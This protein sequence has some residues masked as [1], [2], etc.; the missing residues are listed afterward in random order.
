MSSLTT[1]LTSSFASLQPRMS[2][3][4]KLKTEANGDGQGE[5]KKTVNGRYGE[6]VYRD[7]SQWKARC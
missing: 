1:D 6:G 3:L 2:V 4:R 7:E 5:T